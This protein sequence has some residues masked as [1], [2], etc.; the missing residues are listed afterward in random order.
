MISCCLFNPSGPTEVANRNAYYLDLQEIQAHPYWRF[1]REFVQFDWGLD[2]AVTHRYLFETA[3]GYL[4]I[5]GSQYHTAQDPAVIEEVTM[6]DRIVASLR[7]KD[8]VIDDESPFA[9]SWNAYG[10]CW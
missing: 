5:G 10:L 4:R 8:D 2:G 6:N 9:S 1:E 7:A 3:Q